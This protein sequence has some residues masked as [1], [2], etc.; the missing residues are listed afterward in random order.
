MNIKKF[1]GALKRYVE[2]LNEAGEE[3]AGEAVKTILKAV[4]RGAFC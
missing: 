3:N 4:D 2:H 1:I